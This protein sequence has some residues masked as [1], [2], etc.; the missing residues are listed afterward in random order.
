MK[1]LIEKEEKKRQ[2]LKELGIDYDI[3]SIQNG[4]NE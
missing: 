4:T 2:K 1:R 3:P